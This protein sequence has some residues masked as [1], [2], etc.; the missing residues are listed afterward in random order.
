MTAFDQIARCAA[1]QWAGLPPSERAR[2]DASWAQET[3]AIATALKAIPLADQIEHP[4]WT[5]AYGLGQSSLCLI[6]VKED[7]AHADHRQR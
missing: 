3:L 2:L 1:R 5:V 7:V 6:G 4:V